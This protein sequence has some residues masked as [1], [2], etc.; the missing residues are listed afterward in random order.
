[1]FRSFARLS[2]VLVV[3]LALGLATV[4]PASAG[5][6]R[7]PAAGVTNHWVAGALVWFRTALGIAPATPRSTS[8]AKTTIIVLDPDDTGGATVNT[9][10]CI[11]PMGNRVP[12]HQLPGT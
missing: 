2:L 9:G 3:A 11:D 1:M 7:R 6:M 12:C 5:E 10:S 4:S 8:A